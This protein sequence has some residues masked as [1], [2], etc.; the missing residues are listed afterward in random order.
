MSSFPLVIEISP[1]KPAYE[2]IIESVH[3]AVATGLL[4]D[5]DDFPSVR[6]LSKAA[7]INPNTA[8]KAVQFLISERTLEV[9]PGRGTRV[10]RQAPKSLEQKVEMIEASMEKVVIEAKRAGLSIEEF[11]KVIIE[12]WDNLSEKNDDE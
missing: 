5:G 4:K 9:L 11:K 7:K 12:Q 8:H 1:G 6:A 3:K 10:A 2:Q